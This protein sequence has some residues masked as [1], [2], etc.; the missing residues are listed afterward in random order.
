M[1][2]YVVNQL[3]YPAEMVNINSINMKKVNRNILD[4]SKIISRLEYNILF[5]NYHIF[6]IKT[7]I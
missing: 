3:T 1:W 5:M 6:T 4:I 2:A 7:N